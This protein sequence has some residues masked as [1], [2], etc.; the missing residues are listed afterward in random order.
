MASLKSR[1]RC[2][3]CRS[4][5]Q[6]I[7]GLQQV[8]LSGVPALVWVPAFESGLGLSLALTKRRWAP[9]LRSPDSVRCPVWGA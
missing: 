1:I 4:K 5:S 6:Q 8:T 2:G 9:A 7:R 3:I